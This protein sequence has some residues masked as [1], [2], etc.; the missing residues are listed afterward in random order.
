MPKEVYDDKFALGHDSF[1][2]SA[3]LSCVTN[4]AVKFSGVISIESIDRLKRSTSLSPTLLQIHVPELQGLFDVLKLNSTRF[5]DRTYIDVSIETLAPFSDN[6][7]KPISHIDQSTLTGVSALMPF[8][9]A[10]AFFG[11]DDNT[12]SEL[13]DYPRFLTTYGQGDM[14]VI[15]Q[16]LYDVVSGCDIKQAFHLGI[17]SDGRSLLILDIKQPGLIT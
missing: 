13:T 2:E 11:A 17:G 5:E 7:P 3:I 16:N 12:F 14:I 6:D 1:T 9:G 15:R 10:P 8:D 4:C